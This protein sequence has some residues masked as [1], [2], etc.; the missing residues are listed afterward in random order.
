MVRGRRPTCER[1]RGRV[2]RDGFNE[3]GIRESHASARRYTRLMAAGRRVAVQGDAGPPPP[4]IPS[5]RM[6]DDDRELI[7]RWRNG[8]P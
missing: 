1:G 6:L 4:E 8:E 7:E 3:Y 2:G 5:E